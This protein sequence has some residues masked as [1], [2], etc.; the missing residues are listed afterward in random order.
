MK[1]KLL[2]IC[3]FLSISF[4]NAQKLIAIQNG[5][6]PSFY[7]DV[8][9][10]FDNAIEGDTLYFPGGS[11]N[12][13]RTIDKTLHIIGTGHNPDSSTATGATIFASEIANTP[14]L[15]YTTGGGGTVTGIAFANHSG[16]NGGIDCWNIR[17]DADIDNLLLDRINLPKGFYCYLGVVKNLLLVRSTLYIFDIREISNNGILPSGL[18]TNCVI[19]GN[20]TSYADNLI[21]ENNNFLRE[22][23]NG[24]SCCSPLSAKSSSVINNIF[25]RYA[26]TSLLANS[27][28]SSFR[29][30]FGIG[31]SSGISNTNYISN[32]YSDT[33]L[34]FQNMFVNYGSG[35]ASTTYNY[36]M[37]LV[38]NSPLFSLS[39]SNS[40]IGIYGGRF[41]WKE[42]S[43]PFNPHIVSKNISGSTDE[44][45]NLPIQIEV[46]AQ[47]N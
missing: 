16:C 17:V 15:I 10:A 9:E 39:N 21:I 31:G 30:N 36:D 23:G 1:T 43:T 27:Q 20:A 42:G 2:L 38:D 18:I 11:F 3:S 22:T 12:L 37:H 41:P 46:Q 25:S 14:Q 6:A 13:N 19:W 33:G 29:N 47:E 4:I 44:N 32:N 7:E 24:N 35:N 5:N 26:G 28:N 45:G 40:Q 8:N 34:T